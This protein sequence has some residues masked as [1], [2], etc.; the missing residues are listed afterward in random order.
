M[1]SVLCRLV[2]CLCVI[3]TFFGVL[4]ESSWAQD[5]G[6]TWS[7]NTESDLAGYKI[8]RTTAPTECS[9]PAPVPTAP[10][11]SVGLVTVYTDTFPIVSGTVCWEITA[12]DTQGNES[13]RSNRVTKVIVNLP[14]SAPSRL[15]VAGP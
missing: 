9:N 11:A 8:Y 15:S 3:A 6:L 2:V 13:P 4:S 10:I 7:A 5:F 14:P 12:V 1:K